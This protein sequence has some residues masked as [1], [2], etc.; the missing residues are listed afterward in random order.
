MTSHRQTLNEAANELEHIA[1]D[2][3]DGETIKGK[4]GKDKWARQG[5]AEVA[6]LR[7]LAKRV[8]ALAVWR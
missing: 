1:Q 6:R 5:K 3:F 2:I 4:W 7:K 8:R